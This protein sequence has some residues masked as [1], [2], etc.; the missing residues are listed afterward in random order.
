M[1]Q[2]PQFELKNLWL[3]FLNYA[4]VTLI[5]FSVFIFSIHAFNFFEHSQSLVI[6]ISLNIATLLITACS[7]ISFVHYKSTNTAILI[8][9]ISITIPLGLFLPENKTITFEHIIFESRYSK[10]GDEIYSIVYNGGSV[11]IKKSTLK[12]QSDW[13]K[14]V[15]ELKEVIH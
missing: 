1:R 8:D 13:K 9:Q 2:N 6:I 5:I 10:K 4:I 11:E 14:L 12:F 3:D 15:Y 7:I